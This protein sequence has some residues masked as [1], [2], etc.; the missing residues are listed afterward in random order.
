MSTFTQDSFATDLA[1]APGLGRR[2]LLVDDDALQLKVMKLQLELAGFVVDDGGD[3]KRAITLLEQGVVRP[4]AIVS[5][6]VMDDLDGFALCHAV[7]RSPA[8]ARIPVVLV[9]S[10]FDEA[11]DRELARAVGASALVSRIPSQQPCIEALVRSLAEGPVAGR[12]GSELPPSYAQRVAHQLS[13]M[14]EKKAVAEARFE[15]LFEH[16][17]DVVAVLSPDGTILDA[18]R[19]WEEVTGLSREHLRGKSVACFAAHGHAASNE[20]IFKEMV[21]S[22]GGRTPPTPLQRADGSTAFFEF[23]NS[24]VKVD[25]IDTVFSVGRDVT[26]LL[27]AQAALAASEA[28]YRSLV[29]HVPDVIW[30]ATKDWQYTYFSPN[31]EKISGW[32]AH[33]ILSGTAGRLLE[34]VHPDDLARITA[35]REATAKTG[36]PF[37]AECRWQHRDGRWLW[38]DIRAVVRAESIDG[39][40]SDITARKKLEEQVHCAQKLEA[41]GQLTAG[42]A[43]DFNNVLAVIA[44]NASYLDETLAKGCDA[45]QAACDIVDAAACAGKISKQLLAFSRRTACTPRPLDLRRVVAEIDRMIAP[46]VGREIVV[47]VTSAGDLGLVCADAGQIGQV[48]MNLVVNARDAMA[49]KGKLVISMSNVERAEVE[50]TRTGDVPPGSYVRLSVKDNGSG[51]SEETVGRIFDPFFTTKPE[52]LGTGLG[53][54]TS[55]GIV[56]HAGGTIVV[57]TALG[58]G[59]TFHVDLP[60]LTAKD[61]CR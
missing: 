40:L 27:D 12:G 2:V 45:H 36:A 44:A 4:D 42:L 56:R 32:T 49:G 50:A 34:R 59:T 37:S 10:A 24:I 38:V 39:I 57:E 58:L 54:S 31:I 43:H 22:G 51:M 29:E 16:A 6:V 30:T 9:S 61:A 19:R 18:N 26:S 8:L 55:Y 15:L 21:A 48:L 7:R 14:S 20:T 60:R 33:E 25:G 28:H 13:R 5:D 3:G 47:E 46:A 11:A 23:S 52:G 41:V 35:A 17:L 53:L 1:Q